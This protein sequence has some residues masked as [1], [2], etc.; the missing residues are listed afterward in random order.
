MTL[1][2]KKTTVGILGAGQLG[3]LT[4]Q[5][6]VR[7]GAQ[8]IFY[9]P[10]PHSPAFKTTSRTIIADWN[11]V[12]S[13]TNFFNACD[14]LT[15]EFENVKTDFLHEAEQQSG[16]FI[17]PNPNVL[18]ITQN[19]K[20]EKEFFDSF[21]FNCAPYKIFE[22]KEEALS[23]SNLKYFP[24]ILKTLTGGYDGKGQ[25]SILNINDLKNV[26]ENFFPGILEKRI[27]LYAEASVIVARNFKNEIECF[28]VLQNIHKNGILH[29]TLYPSELPLSLQQSL[30]ILAKQVAEKLNVVGLLTC[31]FF[32]EKKENNEFNIYF[33]ELAPR[34][35]NS[36]HIT[37]KA[38]NVSQFDL[39][40]RIL[41][42]LPLIKPVC[43]IEN[44]TL[45]MQNILGEDLS[46]DNDLFT[47]GFDY[48]MYG[49]TEAKP[50]RKMGHS[51]FL[52]KIR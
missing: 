21:G 3:L 4:A 1:T 52:K 29:T 14:I 36:G 43:F 23:F 26:N 34:P 18:K 51:Y 32:I 49:K 45:M 33:N 2:L 19:R 10:N 50:E 35:H 38:F 39:L 46:L 22:S 15:Y 27:H 31:E 7:Y 12:Q 24:A 9:D 37:L 20:L 6:L 17:F 40:A 5:S 41:L 30:T 8:V 48:C 11:N 16:K 25:Q 44:K 47:Q 28:P 13:L 42:N